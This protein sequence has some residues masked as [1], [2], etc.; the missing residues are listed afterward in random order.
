MHVR[1]GV[2]LKLSL[3]PQVGFELGENAEHSTREPVFGFF[4]GDKTLHRLRPSLSLP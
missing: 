2:A 3:A 4:G 1:L